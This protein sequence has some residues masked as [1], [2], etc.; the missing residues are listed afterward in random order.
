MKKDYLDDSNRYIKEKKKHLI[1]IINIIALFV[2]VGVITNFIIYPVRQKSISM[3]PDYSSQSIIMVSPVA[4]KVNRGDVFLV[5]SRVSSNANFFEK[6]LDYFVNFFTAKQV[7]FLKSDDNYISN[8]QLRR[9]VGLPGDTIYMKDYVTYIKPAGEK[10]F[11]TE[12]EITKKIYDVTFYVPP[13]QWDSSIGVKG[14]FGEI[15]LGMDE[16]FVLS[17][18]RKSS[19][20]SRL[21]GP[22]K[23]NELAAK[24]LFSYFP[25]ENLKK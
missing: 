16:Y 23:S 19:M 13:A 1:L 10:H 5:K 22:V 4:K 9:V 24:V 20:D 6:T 17:D 25:I 3:S 15:E 2:I 18:Y 14:S 21:W 11:L 8:P 7:S 12:F